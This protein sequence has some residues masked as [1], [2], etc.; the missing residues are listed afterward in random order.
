MNSLPC[1]P[2]N[3]KACRK[4]G[5]R[6][7]K[8]RERHKR[9]WTSLQSQT[10]DEF[11]PNNGIL[12]LFHLHSLV[13]SW[14]TQQNNMACIYHITSVHG[15]CRKHTQNW[16]S[17]FLLGISEQGSH[18]PCVKGQKAVWGDL[19]LSDM[20]VLFS[21]GYKMCRLGMEDVVR[22]HTDFS[23]HLKQTNSIYLAHIYTYML[24]NHHGLCCWKKKKLF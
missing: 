13:G 10:Y 1:I 3:I 7:D 5:D 16:A 4:E 15:Q 23:F 21:W 18:T 22:G 8:N 2:G 19:C 6:R 11:Q 24:R 17:G 12:Q 20:T 14:I 9:P